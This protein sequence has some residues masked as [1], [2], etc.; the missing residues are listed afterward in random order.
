MLRY[1]N[2]SLSCNVAT[3]GQCYR[4]IDY[5]FTRG[6]GTVTLSFNVCK[7]GGS[8]LVME[9]APSSP[10]R[11]YVVQLGLLDSKERGREV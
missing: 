10:N 8:F 9:M 5:W 4:L 1:S 2:A 11:L 3:L 6:Y 7:L